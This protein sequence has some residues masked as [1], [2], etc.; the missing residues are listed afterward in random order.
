LKDFHRFL[1]TVEEWKFENVLLYV[2]ECSVIH[3]Q[4]HKSGEA[5]K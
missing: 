1:F 5:Q 2:E 4:L 3:R